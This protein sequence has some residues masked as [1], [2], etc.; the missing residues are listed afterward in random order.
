M[1]TGP[2]RNSTLSLLNYAD[3]HLHGIADN[4]CCVAK[5]ARAGGPEFHPDRHQ[6]VDARSKLQTTEA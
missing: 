4:V 6:L 5:R 3:T 1:V 2:T